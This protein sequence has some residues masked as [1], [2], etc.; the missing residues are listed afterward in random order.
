MFSLKFTEEATEILAEK[1]ADRIMNKAVDMV[2]VAVGA[3]LII[4]VGSYLAHEILETRKE[5]F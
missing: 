5:R 3:T 1:I 2:F 4:S